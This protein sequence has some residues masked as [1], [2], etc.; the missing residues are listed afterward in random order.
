MEKVLID[1]S[2]FIGVARKEPKAEQALV[3]IGQAEV[4]FCDVVLAEILAG[5]RDHIEYKKT[6]EHITRSYRILPITAE[7]CD[8]FREMLAVKRPNHSV[9]ISDYFIA[10]TAIVHACPLLTLNKKH[11]EHLHG[12][13]LV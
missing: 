9:H 12:L 1:S 6:F 5:A 4:L 13:T 3:R 8:R 7:V 11:F 10:A 2:I